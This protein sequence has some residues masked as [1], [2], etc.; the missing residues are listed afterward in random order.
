MFA[1]PDIV[2]LVARRIYP[3]VQ[4]TVHAYDERGQFLASY[5]INSDPIDRLLVD[6]DFI[7]YAMEAHKEDGYSLEHVRWVIIHS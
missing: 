7:K 6:D 1:Y 5:P 4:K 3:M 2:N